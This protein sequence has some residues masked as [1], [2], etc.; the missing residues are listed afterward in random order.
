MSNLSIKNYSI[1]FNASWHTTGLSKSI[2]KINRG[3]LYRE[4]E[5]LRRCAPRRS[6]R[7]KRYFVDGHDGNLLTMG[8]SNRFEE[9]LAIAIWRIKGLW[10]RPGRGRF[11]LLDYQFPLKAHQ[12]D[13]GIGKVDLFGITV[14]NRP[15]VIELKVRP[16]QDNSRGESPVA[17]LMQGLRYAAIVE[18]NQDA[19]AKEVRDICNVKIV[20]APPIV[21]IL[22]PEGWWH[23]WLELHGSTRKAA[24]CWEPE[25]AKLAH[26][27]EG[28]L[29]VVVECVALEDFSHADIVYGSDG[30][31]HR[32]TT[33]PYFIPFDQVR[34]KLSDLLCLPSDLKA[35]Q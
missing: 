13:K 24:G 21:Q 35:K 4:Y 17:A 25:F 8:G 34:P 9:H 3:I 18:A 14:D 5:E 29:G 1:L 19:I 20:K 2:S 28:Q 11:R 23:G 7:G 30:M 32:S 16:Q 6:D 12:S 26:D 15:M 31:S 27:I 22:A 33:S 10:P